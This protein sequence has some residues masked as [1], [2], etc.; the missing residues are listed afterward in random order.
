MGSF[1]T[2][3][4]ASSRWSLAGAEPSSSPR[5]DVLKISVRVLGCRLPRSQSDESSP[6]LSPFHDLSPSVVLGC[7]ATPAPP[8]H[9]GEVVASESEAG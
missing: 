8:T 2:R 9:P 5:A 6:V 7:L 1:L 3:L 4:G